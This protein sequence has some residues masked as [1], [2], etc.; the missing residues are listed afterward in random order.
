MISNFKDSIR[1]GADKGFK[2]SRI[3]VF[4]PPV[5]GQGF[6]LP[7]GEQGIQRIYKFYI[8]AWLL[9]EVEVFVSKFTFRIALKR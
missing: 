4:N 8:R 7:G 3:Q 9:N 2:D 6:N 5:G 1:R